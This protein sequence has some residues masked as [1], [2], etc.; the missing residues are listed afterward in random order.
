MKII[1]INGPARSGKDSL[2]QA[3]SR[4]THEIGMKSEI[5]KFA[6][7]LKE[8]AH[9][10]FGFPNA[11]HDFFE[12]CKDVP[13]EYLFGKTWREI[14]IAVSEKLF[15]PLFGADIFGKLLCQEVDLLQ[16][17]AR[18]DL[19]PEADFF[20]V[21]DSGFTAEARAVV[22]HFGADNILLVRL[23]RD[24][25]TFAGDSRGYIEL[26]GVKTKEY[27]LGPNLSELNDVIA[28]LFI[29][30]QGRKS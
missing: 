18:E 8:K 24:G 7:P 15:K 19:E 16:K 12:N 11:P 13:Q 25:Y 27:N 28:R 3:F 23:A 26:P 2:A 22:D 21:S 4:F 9:A 29:S 6:Q 1:L 10:L 5:T 17:I 30:S 20:L 14:Y